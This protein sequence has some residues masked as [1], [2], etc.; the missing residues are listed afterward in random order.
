M[1][2][3]RN[4]CTTLDRNDWR[5]G[6]DPLVLKTRDLQCGL[7]SKRADGEK[8]QE[9]ETPKTP[10]LSLWLALCWLLLIR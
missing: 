3:L 4:C 6:N 8:G 2:F 10:F 5:S 7:Y 1:F 9:D